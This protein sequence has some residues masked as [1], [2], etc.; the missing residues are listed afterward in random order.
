MIEIIRD[1]YQW[2]EQ[3]SLVKQLDFYHTYDYHYLSKKDNELPILIKY[4]DGFTSLL[5]PLLLRNIENSNYKDAISVYGYAGL[6]ALNIDENFKKE[7]FHN[8]LN[9]FFNEN[10]IVTVF[11]RLH[12]FL[13]CQETILDELGTITTL[14]KV[15]YKDLSDT[16][17]NQRAQYNRRLKTYLNKSR[18]LCTIIKGKIEDHLDSFINLYIENMR[19]VIADAS[20][21]FDKEYFVQLLSSSDFNSEFSLCIHNE[22]QEIIAGAIFI[23]TGNIVQYHLSGLSEDYMDLNP[24][25]LIID[26]MRI[27]STKEGYKY[28]NLGGGKGS[29]E[30]S[31][32]KFKSG[33]SKDFKDFK[34]WKYVVDENAYKLLTENHL[35]CEIGIASQNKDFFPAYRSKLEMV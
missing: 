32:F 14:G 7:N 3:L 23:K 2:S 21:F 22:S 30:D 28:L 1:K 12:P 29:K 11:S 24:I 34:I 9:A 5:F 8:E 17:E 6:L 19:R 18:R 25:K 15:V 20:Y 10:K 26:D 35:G 4:T 13:D 16:I 27:K 31:L 33:F